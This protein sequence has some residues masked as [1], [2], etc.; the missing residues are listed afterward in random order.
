MLSLKKK[1]LPLIIPFI[2]LIF[3]L[4]LKV[5][6]N[7]DI[8]FR[9]GLKDL[10]LLKWE[11]YSAEVCCDFPTDF[12]IKNIKKIDLSNF[13]GHNKQGEFSVYD[14]F[15]YLENGSEKILY[16]AVFF[17][18]QSNFDITINSALINDDVAI[19]NKILIN[20][21]HK[22]SYPQ[23]INLENEKKIVS[24]EEAQSE[25]GYPNIYLFENNQLTYV[26]TPIHKRLI[27]VTYLKHNGIFFAFGTDYNL[28]NN[29]KLRIFYGEDI[30]SAKFTEH[31]L[32]PLTSNKSA[33]NTAGTFLRIKDKIYRFTMNNKNSLRE[34][35]NLY[36]ISKL[37]INEFD[38]KLIKTNIL[39]SVKKKYTNIKKIHHISFI[40][41]QY[42][43]GR[44]KIYFDAAHEWKVKMHDKEI[45]GNFS[46]FHSTK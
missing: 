21:S 15:V 23:I 36:E 46:L 33:N 18:E 16:E 11:V 40:D 3:P 45:R 28:N 6:N 32:S 17:N 1:F 20:P 35:I 8:F 14:P 29:G 12:E 26:N 34:G 42:N 7:T 41:K 10:I 2:I 37:N 22:V 4:S 30:M 27:D 5:T 31:P 9:L 19:E 25:E 38:E 24:L 43:E 44:L 39:S 13:E